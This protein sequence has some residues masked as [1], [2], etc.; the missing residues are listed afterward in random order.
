MIFTGKK[1]VFLS[2]SLA[3]EWVGILRLDEMRYRA[4]FMGYPVCVVTTD[5]DRYLNLAQ[6]VTFNVDLNQGQKPP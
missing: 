6:S 2:D 4:E 3:E 1:P 5:Q